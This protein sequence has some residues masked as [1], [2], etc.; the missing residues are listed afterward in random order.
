M[1]STIELA[2]SPCPNDTFIFYAMAC[3]KIP[4]T[5][6]YQP[7]LADVEVLNHRALCREAPL[8]K[9]SFGVF[10]DLKNNY[11]LLECGGALGFKNGPLLIASK[12]LDLQNTDLK[13]AIPG[14]HTTANRLLTHFFP[15][16]VKKTEVL[17]S[18]I[19]E[20]IVQGTAD[21][22]L[23]IH[24]SR[25]TYAQKGLVELADLGN[26][27]FNQYQLPLPLGAI[28]LRNDYR[29]MKNTIEKDIR[30]SIRYAY[31]NYNEVM[32]YVKS[33]AIEM[34]EEVMKKHIELY[35]NHFS[36]N[37]SEEGHRAIELLTGL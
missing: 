31:E 34:D 23:I 3:N 27:W 7:F 16:L 5:F 19:E 24:E 17:F 22:G 28:V 8:S 20:K 13:I 30:N 36:E 37:I 1:P 9:I 21:V 4:T 11:T 26:L 6:K 32:A 12:P 25:F 10:S 2:Y 29:E 35:V 15:H 14:L 33:Y 18:D